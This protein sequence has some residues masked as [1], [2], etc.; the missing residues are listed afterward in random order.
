MFS[1]VLPSYPIS[2]EKD[3]LKSHHYYTLYYTQIN[4]WQSCAILLVAFRVVDLFSLI[5]LLTLDAN[6]FNKW[7]ETVL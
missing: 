6:L 4:N 7:E 5:F 2:G 3:N 1:K